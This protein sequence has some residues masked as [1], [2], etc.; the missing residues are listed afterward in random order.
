QFGVISIPT[1]ILFK[2]GGEAH[3]VVGAYPKTKLLGELEP[4]LA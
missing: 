1:M 2:N 3:R 4:K